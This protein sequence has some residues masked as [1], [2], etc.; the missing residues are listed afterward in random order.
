MLTGHLYL[1]VPMPPPPEEGALDEDG[2]DA[3]DSWYPIETGIAIEG[4]EFAQVDG[5]SNVF[6][7]DQSQYELVITATREPD[8]TLTV[9][10]SR[11][12]NLHENTLA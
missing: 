11:H 7:C 4:H 9:V 8:G 2:N 6:R 1:D 12:V 3:F 5:R 10:A